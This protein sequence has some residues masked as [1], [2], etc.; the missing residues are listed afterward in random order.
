[1]LCVL[2]QKKAVRHFVDLIVKVFEE[3]SEIPPGL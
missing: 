2:T 1:M 3:D